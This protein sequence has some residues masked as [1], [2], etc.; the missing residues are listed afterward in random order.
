MKKFFI[1]LILFAVTV[2]VFISCT[3][4][5][6]SISTTTVKKFYNSINVNHILVNSDVSVYIFCI[7]GYKYLSLYNSGVIQMKEEDRLGYERL[8]KCE[9]EEK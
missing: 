9:C 4:R 5:D 2:I 7:D 8:V 3:Q 1:V 6:I